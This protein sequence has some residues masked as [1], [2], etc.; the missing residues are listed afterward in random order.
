MVCFENV[1][2]E[3]AFRDCWPFPAPQ[4]R[5]IYSMTTAEEIEKAIEQFAPSELARRSCLRLRPLTKQASHQMA[6]RFNEVADI[7]AEAAELLL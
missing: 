3:A 7:I 1:V 6:A 2:P 5:Y 4:N